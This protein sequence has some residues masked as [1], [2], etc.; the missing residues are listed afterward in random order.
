MPIHRIVLGTCLTLGAGAIAALRAVLSKENRQRAER[1][2]NEEAPS[3]NSALEAELQQVLDVAVSRP[4]V[5]LTPRWQQKL[6][7]IAQ[8]HSAYHSPLP[9]Q[10]LFAYRQ[11]ESVV[12]SMTYDELYEVFGGNPPPPAVPREQVKRLPSRDFEVDDQVR[13]GSASCPICLEEYQK[14]EKLTVLPVCGHKFH[15]KCVG[16]WLR[17]RGDC[18]ICRRCVE[19]EQITAG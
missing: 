8:R 18:P 6:L 2:A 5:L 15:S 12:E 16:R 3:V 1:A 7:S 10:L 4:R 14:G 11:M 19:S 13:S 17:T 9:W